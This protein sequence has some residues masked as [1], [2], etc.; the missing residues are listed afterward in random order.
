MTNGQS[1]DGR[2]LSKGSLY[3]G[4]HN[5]SSSRLNGHN[6]GIPGVMMNG[7]ANGRSRNSNSPG[8]SNSSGGTSSISPPSS[9]IQEQQKSLIPGQYPSDVNYAAPFNAAQ[10]QQRRRTTLGDRNLPGMSAPPVLEEEQVAT[11]WNPNGVDAPFE[12]RAISRRNSYVPA[13][14]N[15]PRAGSPDTYVGGSGGHRGSSPVSAMR[16]SHVM[17]SSRYSNYS[18]STGITS[19]S[20]VSTLRNDGNQTRSQSPLSH[21]ITDPSRKPSP[22]RGVGTNIARNGN[23]FLQQMQHRDQQAS[24]ATQ[25]AHEHQA[26][27]A[28]L[29]GQTVPAAIAATPASAPLTGAQPPQPSSTQTQQPTSVTQKLKN[30]LSLSLQTQLPSTTAAAPPAVPEEQEEPP[31][32]E[33]ITMS[34]AVREGGGNLISYRQP[35]RSLYG[36]GQTGMG[37]LSAMSAGTGGPGSGKEETGSFSGLTLT[38]GGKGAAGDRYFGQRVE[39]GDLVAMGLENAF[40]RL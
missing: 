24:S 36:A 20:P 38:G 5:A 7:V 18:P 23:A 15:S 13:F 35:R 29:S 17:S 12:H 6:N 30:R 26:A 2:R 8:P 19:A 21:E 11:R 10:R 27:L 22:A 33:I 3:A 39:M 25:A 28:A 31:M 34:P 32:Q 14:S 40:G 9:T 37:A 1:V 16:G 4:V